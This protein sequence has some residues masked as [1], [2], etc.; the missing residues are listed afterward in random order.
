MSLDTIKIQLKDN[1]IREFPKNTNAKD[2]VQSI[3]TSLAKS[4]L[5]VRIDGIEKDLSTT[6]DRDCT[7]EVLTIESKEGR[8]IFS[9]SSAH[10]LGQAVQ[11]LYPKALLTVGPVIENGPGFFYYDIDFGED[12][13]VPEDLIKIEKEMEKIVKENLEVH[14][15]EL[16]IPAALEKFNS[17]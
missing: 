15:E 10:L 3:S 2:I 6:L 7:F 13:L 9:H 12:K 1:S 14:R 17:M 16:S 11:R 8:E 4:A 5:A